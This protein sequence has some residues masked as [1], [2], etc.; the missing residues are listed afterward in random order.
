MEK[1]LSKYY[2]GFEGEPDIQFIYYD[3]KGEQKVI[4]KIWEGYFDE[5]MSTIRPELSGWTGL[6]YFYHLHEGWYKESPWKIPD[7]KSAIQQFQSL[8][9]EALNIKTQEVYKE[10]IELLLD[11]NLL[12]K[13]VWIAYD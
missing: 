10:I 8:D 11:A 5:I 2:D 1:V 13:D 3:N 9:I 12:D 4:L 7:L 6:S